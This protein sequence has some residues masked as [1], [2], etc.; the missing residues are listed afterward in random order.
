MKRKITA[1]TRAAEFQPSSVNAEA[2][3]IELVWTTGARVLR[4]SW[5]DQFYEELEVSERAIDL[6]RLNSGAPFL[7]SHNQ[8][9]LS[10]V[11]GVVEKA[12]VRG[13]EGRAIVRFSE[14]PEVEG[15]WKDVALGIIRNVSVGYRVNK[16]EKV[17]DAD[18]VAVM[19]ATAWEPFELSAVAVG[20]DGSAGF[21]EAEMEN[22]CEIEGTDM[23]PTNEAVT[24]T[25]VEKTPATEE[26]VEAP[27]AA[28]P[29]LDAA[30]SVDAEAVRA[31]A[32]AT[33]RAR[34]AEIFEIVAKAKLGVEIARNLIE[35]GA[36]VEQ[37]RKGI[38]EMIST[39]ETIATARVEAGAQD[40]VNTRKEAATAALL[41]R[42]NPGIFKLEE[43]GREYVG[44]S[45]VRIA[46]DFIGSV[47]GMTR[48]QIARRALQTS[49]FVELLANVGSKTLLQAY[50]I[51]PKSF[52][53]F[54]SMGTLP[55]YK[56]AKRV[57][58]GELPNLLPIAEGADYVQVESIG[59]KAET[60]HLVK[61]GRMVTLT[62][63][64][65]VNDDLQ[66]FARL[67]Q[68]FGAAAARL[69]SSLVYGVLTGNPVMADGKA[70]FHADHGNLASASA[71]DVAGLAAARKLMR[72]QKGLDGQDYLDLMPAFLVCG[73][74][75]EVAARQILSAQYMPNT[76]GEVNPFMASMQLIVDPRIE[77]NAWYLI[78]SPST[79]DTIE[80]AM[81]EGMSG[82]EMAQET[83]FD[84]DGVK[85]KC[86]HI[87]GVKAISHVGMVKNPGV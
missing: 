77:G 40:E 31:E 51:Q 68:L 20:A 37:A 61:H 60:I 74:N 10:D 30:P 76:V 82:P 5:G 26:A 25:V 45:L 1:L 27:V 21:R 42:A 9:S 71:I 36:S 38:L 41:H 43:K 62:D 69:E 70:L 44:M 8:N 86:K 28:A 78:A 22:T 53:P 66:A 12:W 46:E 13:G 35:G 81:L 11:L 2:R 7:N 56:P 58:F 29:A 49:D 64:L 83:W 75:Q 48:N 57:S 6:S 24:E 85:F 14:R 16:F 65:I 67:P 18:G 39:K 34:A 4:S 72:V 87:I 32:A 3:T 55:D 80:V 23:E 19:R 84:N 50:A 63:T 54:V 52:Q 73:P 33:E 59:E 79:V 15:I 17:G 47:R